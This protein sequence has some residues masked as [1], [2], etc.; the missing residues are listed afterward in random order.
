MEGALHLY[1]LS[2]SRKPLCSRYDPA[3]WMCLVLL[4]L[5]AR[6]PVL[7]LPFVTIHSHH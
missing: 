3:S 5:F 7:L 6:H 4:A 2:Y 1:T